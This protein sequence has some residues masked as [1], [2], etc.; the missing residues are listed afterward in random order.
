MEIG[1]Y[2][3]ELL[4]IHDCVIIPGFGGFVA[5]YRPADVNELAWTFSPPSKSI[6]FNRHLIH[7]DGLLID[8]I[9]QKNNMDYSKSMEL[10]KEF[11]DRIMTSVSNNAKFQVDE[12][13]F[14]YFDA[15]RK[16]QF[17]DESTTNFLIESYGLSTF[18]FNPVEQEQEETVRAVTYRSSPIRRWIYTGVAASL[19]AAM[20]LIPVKTGYVEQMNFGFLKKD[21]P[22]Q[23]IV[24]EITDAAVDGGTENFEWTSLTCYIIVG[25]FKDFSNARGMH[26][27]LSG[28]GHDPKIMEASNGYYRV[29]IHSTKD[30]G[31]AMEKLSAIRKIEGF[32]SAWMLRE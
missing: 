3:K 20:V 23:H 8:Y 19:V 1:K 13:G 5:N 26:Q 14:F 29:A 12:V 7:N 31:V 15:Q 21:V 22:Q 11:A 16:L 6:L 9:S 10:V 27:R 32:E 28:Q 4:F 30:A 18:V 24:Q 17:Q 25:S 2:I